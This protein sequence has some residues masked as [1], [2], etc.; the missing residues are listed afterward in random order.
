[1]T[2]YS[3]AIRQSKNIGSKFLGN[4][5]PEHSWLLWPSTC[6]RSQAGDLYHQQRQGNLLLNN[7]TQYMTTCPSFEGFRAQAFTDLIKKLTIVSPYL[8]S[9]PE[10]TDH[11]REHFEKPGKSY[12]SLASLCELSSSQ[13]KDSREWHLELLE[14]DYSAREQKLLTHLFASQVR[15]KLF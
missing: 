2:L 15:V 12:L 14:F 8:T 13:G 11:I 9:N 7:T 1:M 3:S 5:K 4:L 10:T 6:W